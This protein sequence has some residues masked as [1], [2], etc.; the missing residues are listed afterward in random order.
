MPRLNARLVS[1]VCVFVQP[2][3][4]SLFVYDFSTISYKLAH[5]KYF[6]STAN[7]MPF[8]LCAWLHCTC[9]SSQSKTEGVLAW[10]RYRVERHSVS[11]RILYYHHMVRNLIKMD[12]RMRIEQLSIVLSCNWP[13]KV[14][15]H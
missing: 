5:L 14:K 11:T 10:L 7:K 9:T 8:I 6:T 1:S 13:R 3:H 4:S 12:E 2:K 15:I